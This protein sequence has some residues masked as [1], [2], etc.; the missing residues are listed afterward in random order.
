MDRALV[1]GLGVSGKAAARFLL[2]KGYAVAGIDA[3]KAQLLENVEVQQLILLGLEIFYEE[4]PIDFRDVRLVVLSPGVHPMHP[5]LVSASSR[6]IPII[7][8][9]EL[10]LRSSTGKVL[11][12]TGTNG[13]TTVTELVEHVLRFAQIPAK[14]LG[15]IGVPLT[16]HFLH[17]NS[18]EVA[19]VELSS[20][21]LETMTSPVFDA[22]VILNITPDH[23]DRYDSMESYAAAKARLQL[24]MKPQ[25][26]LYLYGLIRGEFPRLFTKQAI[27]FGFGQEDVVRLQGLD[28]FFGLKKELSLPSFYEQQGEH[29]RLNALAA[30]ALV[31]HVGVD[32]ETFVQSLE[33]F[34]KPPHRIEF[35]RRIED[36]CYFD[37]SKG[38]N[39][40]A[41]IQAI[42]TM[43][44]PVILI[45]GGVD[46]GSSY[47]PWKEFGSK[48]KQ[49]LAIG[50]AASKI[51]EELG[52]FF[53]VKIVDSLEKAVGEAAYAAV[54][55]DCVLLS[56]GCSSFDMFRDYAHRG[57]EFQKYV[58]MLEERSKK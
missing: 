3:K 55:G 37:D 25:A 2:A 11:A 8:E 27:S 31:R 12:I 51:Q 30:W 57:E 58:R 34:R 41:A 35:V 24:C 54:P 33:T 4:D 23:L 6:G 32:S 45:A 38:T 10:A 47:L 16:Q 14:A 56:P 52:L 9:A 17:P 21:Q 43:Q 53:N 13:K 40:D 26:P 15:N 19:V 49:I 28:V 5:T 39:V 18:Q 20:Y 29:D 22:G 44:G 50:Q 36:V 46:K 42:R 1:L 48:I 7:G